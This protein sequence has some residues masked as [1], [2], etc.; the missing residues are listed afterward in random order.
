MCWVYR[1]VMLKFLAIVRYEKRSNP[2]LCCWVI[3]VKRHFRVSNV[4]APLVKVALPYLTQFSL[5]L[6]T[7]P[8]QHP[9]MKFTK[10]TSHIANTPS[11]SPGAVCLVLS[12]SI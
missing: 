4:I 6:Y 3:K 8:F 10:S 1:L 2:G 7:L 11:P 12:V 9:E 5:C